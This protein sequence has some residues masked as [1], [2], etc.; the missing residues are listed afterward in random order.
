MAKQKDPKVVTV[1]LG[2]DT[3]EHCEEIVRKNQGIASATTRDSYL[4][5]VYVMHLWIRSGNKSGE[6]TNSMR[7]EEATKIVECVINSL[8]TYF[9]I[10]LITTYG[11]IP[12]KHA[13]D[14]TQNTAA[15]EAD[16]DEADEDGADE[17]G[18]DEDGADEDGAAL[19]AVAK[20]EPKGVAVAKNWIN[21]YGKELVFTEHA[22]LKPYHLR[23][24]IVQRQQEVPEYV[25]LDCLSANPQSLKV[26]NMLSADGVEFT[27]TL[28]TETSD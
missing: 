11:T 12:K 1:K 7:P 6:K 28:D 16:E 21:V 17:D 8:K 10:E 22:E 4:A 14:N 15:D 9:D 19:D 27:L 5:G 20:S 13:K 2:N 3:P 24:L 26:S 25:T 23:F 18:A